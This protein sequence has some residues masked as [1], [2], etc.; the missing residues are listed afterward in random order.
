MS[1]SAGPIRRLAVVNRGEPAM[2]LLNAVAEL[3]AEGRTEL[4]TIALFTEPDRQAWFVRAADEAICL[5]PAVVTPPGGAAVPAYLDAARV[6]AALRESR[7]DA[8]WVGWGFV[9][10]HADFV[11]LCDRLDIAFI[12]PDA[13]VMRRLGDKIASKRLAEEAGV[14]VVPWSGGPVDDVASALAAA[15]RIG[16]PVV[17]KATSGGGGRGIRRA[18]GPEALPAAFT[19][20]RAEAAHAFGDPTV[21]VERQV[22]GGRH[23][24]VQVIADRHGTVW[25]P[26]IRDCSIQRHH[27]KVLEESASTALTAAQGDDLRAAAMRLCRAAGYVNAGTVE[28]LYDP[29]DGVPRLMEVNARLQVEHPVTELTTGLDLVK[30]QILVAEGGRLVGD[31]PPVVGHAVE[32]RLAAE[33]PDEDFMPAPG[34]ISHLRLPTGPGIR[35][36]TGVHQGDEVPPQFDSMIAKLIAW[37]HDR[38]EALSRLARALE[39]TTAVVE[40]GATNKTFLLDLVNHPDVRAGRLHTGWLDE[41]MGRGDFSSDSYRAEALL[42]AAVQASE[43]K[44]A[45]MRARFYAAAAR[46]RPE[47]PAHLGQRLEFRFRGSRYRMRVLRTGPGDFLVQVAGRRIPLSIEPVGEYDRRVRIGGR[48]LSVHAVAQ[49]SVHVIEVE[50]VAHRVVVDDGGVVRS[51]APGVVVALPVQPGD[52]VQAGDTVAV[53]EMMKLETSIPAPFAGRVRAVPAV[54]NVQVDGRT[55]LVELEAAGPPA[56]GRAAGPPGAGGAGTGRPA[57]GAVD[58]AALPVPG[59]SGSVA[60]RTFAGLRDYLLGYDREAD[61][62][63]SLLADQQRAY[64]ELPA[65][66]DV[67]RAREDDLLELFTSLCA[68]SRR[69]FDPSPDAGE[70]V[71]SPEQHLITYLR[72][73]ARGADVLPASYQD[74]LRRALRHFGVDGLSPSPAL[75]DALVRLYQATQRLSEVMP[76]VASILDRRLAHR[77]WLSEAET[78]RALLDDLI[79]AG[80]GGYPMLVDLAREVRFRWFDEPVLEAARAAVYADASGDVRRLQGASVEA[81][82]DSYADSYADSSSDSST[83]RDLH[84]ARLVAC[85]Y[86]LRG[87]LLDHYRS[88]DRAGREAVLEAAVR[89]YYRIRHL[90]EVACTEIAGQQLCSAAYEEADGRV[91]LMLAYAASTELARLATAVSTWLGGVP[92]GARPVVDVHVWHDGALPTAE[93]ADR[94][95]RDRFAERVAADPASRPPHRLS[96]TVGET[97]RDGEQAAEQPQLYHFTYTVADGAVV[98]EPLFRNL[99]PMLAERLDLWRL[100]NFSL[101]RLESVEDV[102]LF[103]GVAHSN[104]KDERLFALAEVRDVTPVLDADGRVTGVPLMERMYLEALS[105]IRRYQSH[106]PAAERLLLNQVV[107]YVRPPWTVPPSLW[108]DLAHR[109]AAASRGLGVDQVIARV[110]IPTVSGKLRQQELHVSSPGAGVV[111]RQTAPERVP[112]PVLSE[113]EWRALQTRRRGSHYPYDI[114]RMLTPPQQSSSDLP[115]GDFVEYDLDTAAGDGADR[116]EPVQREYGRNASNVVVGV[117][118]NFTAEYPDGM[119]RVL[120]LGDPSRGMG[121]LAEGECRRI[122]AACDLAD[123]LRVPLEWFAVSAGAKISMTSGTENMDWIAA[124]LRRLIEFTQSGGEVNVVVTGINVGAQPYWNA[125]ATMLM[126]TRGILVMIPESAMV[127]TGKTALDFS[128]G[129]SAEDNLGIGG[130]ERVMG[131][132]GQAQYYAP[133]LE[134]ACDLVLRHYAHTYVVSGERFPRRAVTRDPVDRDVCTSPHPP[135]PGGAA[136]DGFSTVGDV[137]SAQSNA[138]RKK[139]FDIRA[140]LR[141]VTDADAEPLERWPHMRSAENAVVWDARIGGIPV[142][143]VGFES[144]PLPRE[145]FV[146]ADGPTTWT[147]GTL[148]PQSSRKTARAVNAASG[149]RPLVVLANLSGFDG[150]PESMRLRQL[151]YGA[152]IGR[153]VTNFSGPVIFV[154]ISRYHGGAFVVFSKRLNPGMEVA[155]V[156]GSYASVI[157]GAPAAA[158]VFTHEVDRRTRADE[159]VASLARLV[160]GGSAEDGATGGSAE[161]SIEPLRA[162]LQAVTEQVRAEKLG[163]VAEE[164]EAVHSVERARQVGSVDRIIS[165]ADL[166]PYL[167]DALERGMARERERVVRAPAARVEAATGE[168]ILG[169]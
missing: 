6:E 5:G 48:Q 56:A 155:A 164:F 113:Y 66:D 167:V 84:L 1:R 135:L 144:H 107:L 53:L 86:P 51:P 15:E 97:E 93:S 92:A 94:L 105:A 57:D 145:G 73:P 63:A 28:F 55:R 120:L 124:V 127:L 89:R 2:R 19:S 44:A 99:H 64:A 17:V 160:A 36:D 59:S 54:L 78:E 119:S 40:G 95:V 102:Y 104:P 152:E 166:R 11:E 69:V 158:V 18:D 46:G 142:C 39:Q 157:G 139:P 31:A 35:V 25:A 108:Q 30:L 33:E 150:S 47:L 147:S 110:R 112:V 65:G 131:P 14:A 13:A 49:D 114:V 143:L 121:N 154:V 109:Q 42:V 32:V 62:V 41:A 60:D 128:G 58:F 169:R 34:R 45:A 125:E 67:L 159:R 153:A 101:E 37:G 23:I 146:P 168:L 106:R 162:R 82:S 115:P 117:I 27:Q 134:S 22:E 91:R 130:Y 116:L 26:G 129:V 29:A 88:A 141:A 9:A 7:A 137:F 98:E 21:F 50:G 77:R 118:R 68:L 12:G 123:R 132:N 148:F 38:P 10:E 90:T 100:S 4:R 96:V 140:V 20:A 83:A 133:D 122:I 70:A 87:L 149:N 71:R 138:E 80:E 74:R 8:A 72:S 52:E 81:G 24:E 85:P 163:E 76:A 165:A 151:E 111:V 16:Y 3:R 79:A 43:V 126:H 136:G 61:E 156:E 75:D 103:H 161:E